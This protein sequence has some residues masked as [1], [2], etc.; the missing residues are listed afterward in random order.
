[1]EKCTCQ[2]LKKLL[3]AASNEK[4]MTFLMGLNE[5]YD[6]LRTNILSM[7]P[8]PSINKAYSFVQ[9][10]E[11]QKNISNIIQNSQDISATVIEKVYYSSTSSGGAGNWRR[12]AKRVKTEDK[13]CSFCKRR[14]H[15]KENCFKLHPEQKS[16]YQSR[17]QKNSGQ[18]YVANVVEVD[19]DTPLEMYPEKQVVVP[20]DSRSQGL[21][22]F[23][24]AVV[25]AVYHHMMSMIQSGASA[26][27]ASIN[28]TD[29]ILASNVVTYTSNNTQNDWIVDSG[30]TDHMSA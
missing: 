18:R 12:E 2:I 10:I 5:S 20:G 16:S 17:N 29:K 7:E 14:G 9:Q 24:P 8:L 11:S 27:H 3:E 22:K 4:V 25:T 6:M 15:V 1:M 26:D 28:F 23:D 30:A 13:W 19:E 21:Q